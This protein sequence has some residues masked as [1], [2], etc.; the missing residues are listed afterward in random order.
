MV[1][2]N[3]NFF[4][5]WTKV[6]SAL[7]GLNLID[8]Y[9]V[10]TALT[11]ILGVFSQGMLGRLLGSIEH[12]EAINSKVQSAIVSIPGNWLLLP[13]RINDPIS[14]VGAICGKNVT[15]EEHYF[16]NRTTLKYFSLESVCFL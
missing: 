7:V 9:P 1:C 5:L 14:I 10:T 8:N 11:T 6:A 2:K 12:P 4:V 13:I 15:E 3:L 16:S